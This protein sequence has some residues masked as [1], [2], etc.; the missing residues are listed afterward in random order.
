MKTGSHAKYVI[1]LKYTDYYYVFKHFP[2]GLILSADA[3][4]VICY[5][6]VARE[7]IFGISGKA[8][9]SINGGSRLKSSDFGEVSS[10]SGC[11]E[12]A[13]LFYCGT[14]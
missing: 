6:L 10:T 3:M 11:L 5:Y 4:Y 13:T 1:I 12:W 2:F 7:P 14:P 9:V 8:F